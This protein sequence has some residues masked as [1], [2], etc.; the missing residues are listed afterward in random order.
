MKTYA[1]L[2][3]EMVRQTRTHLLNGE[4]CLHHT[5]NMPGLGGCAFDPEVQQ[6]IAR[7]KGRGTDKGGIVLVPSA[8]CLSDLGVTISPR[9][10]RL[11]GQYWPG[12]LSVILP[13]NDSDLAHLAVKGAV[14]FR[15]PTAV[16]LRD[17][18]AGLETPITSTSV[19]HNG[20]P[21][22]LDLEHI[23]DDMADWFDIAVLFE[24]EYLEAP[25]PSTLVRL[26]GNHLEALRE[27]SIPADELERSWEAP[28]VLF[29]CTGNICRSP[30]AEFYARRHFQSLDLPVRVASAG[31]LIAGLSA[32]APG[33]QVLG[34]HGLDGGSHK[35]TQLSPALIRSAWRIYTMEQAHLD[36]IVRLNPNAEGKVF[37]LGEAG[38]LPGDVADPYMQ[39]V[40]QYRETYAILK[41]RI[42]AL[43]HILEVEFNNA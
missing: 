10:A 15:A 19:N 3:D 23:G 25:E 30:M 2:S 22:L 5:G 28:L 40:G 8:D 43:G 6:C 34:E 31:F 27:G 20:E 42:D 13:C 24:R 11:L 18:L 7:L 35:S 33:L 12:N 16:A 4:T 38:G 29:V 1:T 17:W 36:E 14:A 39:P 26:T 41:E 37:T 9:V 21:P 32:S